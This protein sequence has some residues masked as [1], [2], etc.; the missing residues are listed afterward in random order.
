[1]GDGELQVAFGAPD[2][3]A[4]CNSQLAPLAGE[5]SG[6]HQTEFKPA[7]GAFYYIGYLFEVLAD[8]KIA[9]VGMV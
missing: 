1:V 7:P 3:L 2:I 8:A 9:K 4:A 5:G 6:I